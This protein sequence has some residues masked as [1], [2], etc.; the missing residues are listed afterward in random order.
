MATATARR[1]GKTLL[2]NTNSSGNYTGT[3]ASNTG[4]SAGLSNG[5]STVTKIRVFATGSTLKNEVKVY[6]YNS[7]GSVYQYQFS[8]YVPLM[9]Y[10]AG[11][12]IPPWQYSVPCDIPLPSTTHSVAYNTEVDSGA[13]LFA[14]DTVVDY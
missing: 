6:L 1:V 11:E 4:A 8:I 3:S 5:R 7:S 10:T 2:D 14:E 12:V 13:N 9:T